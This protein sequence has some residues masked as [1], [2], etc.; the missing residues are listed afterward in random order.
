MLAKK[1]IN[2]I[3]SIPIL[4][5]YLVYAPLIHACAL[6][7]TSAAD[8][9]AKY[10]IHSTHEISDP[11]MRN[12]VSLFRDQPPKF[13]FDIKK[14]LDPVF[15]G[16]I[17]S[18][19]CSMACVYCGFGALDKHMQRLSPESC[20]AAIDYFF[21][22]IISDG[23]KQCQIQFFG[24]EPF[25]EDDIVDI[26]VHHARMRSERT[27]I[28][29]S[30]E[31]ST[32]GYYSETRARFVGD[33][34]DIAVLSLDGF[35]EFHDKNRPANP[36]TGSFDI[37]VRT[38]KI[39]SQSS[40]ALSIRCCITGDS[41]DSMT[42]IAHWFCKEF[43]PAAIC[44]E[45]LQE[46]DLSRNA[47]LFPPDPLDFSKNYAKAAQVITSYGVR[48]VYAAIEEDSPRH[49]FCPVGRDALIVGPSDTIN[50]C[51]LQKDDWESKGMD[52]SLGKI[53]SNG[54]V[55]L[56]FSSVERVRRYVADKP[57]CIDCFCRYSCAGGCHV[58]NTFPGSSKERTDF[59]RQTRILQA[60]HLLLTLG[61]DRLANEFIQSREAVQDLADHC[62]DALV[63]MDETE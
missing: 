2:T 62:C 16:I 13:T 20:I 6:M 17:P 61:I 43:N 3:F 63:K 4:D 42:D 35:K 50:G 49:T 33:Y 15:L 37:V 52:L 47:G 32:N 45:T 19:R 24:G 39:L 26:T 41:V 10:L 56:D 22:K 28:H 34:I 53:D 14:P 5:K 21:D 58:H 54:H 23:K 60:Y 46:N 38:A 8:M 44:F 55:T 51:Y 31:A 59:C 25:I 36:Q 12:L 18:R 7:N 9:L 27:G 48:P 57:R 29:V 11:E 30:F 40:T 1:N